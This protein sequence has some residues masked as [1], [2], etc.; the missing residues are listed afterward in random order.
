VLTVNTAAGSAT[1]NESVSDPQVGT[2]RPTPGTNALNGSFDVAD[3]SR[4][5]FQYGA[6]AAYGQ[7]TAASSMSCPNDGTAT[8]NI[9]ATVPGL[10]GS[11]HYRLVVVQSYGPL[12]Y[13]QDWPG[14]G[15]S[16]PVGSVGFIGVAALAGCA[17]F[18]AQR[19][20]RGRQR[21]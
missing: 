3:C 11:F 17:L 6:T 5:Y 4:Y 20:R 8:V 18:V 1:W 2:G 19:H 16:L 13:G 21:A 10:S 9:T 14:G 15:T 12:L 7:Q